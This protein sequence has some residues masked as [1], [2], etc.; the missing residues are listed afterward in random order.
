MLKKCKGQSMKTKLILIL[1]FVSNLGIAQTCKDYITDNWKDSRYTDNGDGTITD[2][3]TKLMWKKCSEGQSGNNCGTG[4]AAGMNWQNALA[5]GGSTFAGF[6]DWR[7]PNIK[8]LSSIAILNC[9]S[10]SINETMFPNTPANNFWSA[11]PDAYVSGYAWQ[12]IFNYGV[13]GR[14]GTGSSYRVRLVRNASGSADVGGGPGGVKGGGS[15]GDP[16]P[17]LVP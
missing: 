17:G 11:S 6:S 3:A 2:N 10:P 4:S 12:L 15:L 14:D 1:I 13:I 5:L 8:E 9:Y 7:L 16:D